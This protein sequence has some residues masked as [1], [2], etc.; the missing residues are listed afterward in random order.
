MGNPCSGIKLRVDVNVRGYNA[1]DENDISSVR[2]RHPFRRSLFFAAG[3]F[4][5]DSNRWDFQFWHPKLQEHNIIPA[6]TE[7]QIV[8]CILEHAV[9]VQKCEFVNHNLWWH[10]P[11]LGYVSCIKRWQPKRRFNF[12]RIYL[13]AQ[14][15]VHTQCWN[16][17]T[18]LEILMP[19][20][21]HIHTKYTHTH[22][23]THNGS[24]LRNNDS[25]RRMEKAFVTQQHNNFNTT[26]PE[27]AF[28]NS[29]FTNCPFICWVH[30][31]DGCRVHAML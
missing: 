14:T 10:V 15:S 28:N 4:E 5:L 2:P 23:H 19:R 26:I 30:C 31:C 18:M 22:T 29:K 7:W 3:D 12:G 9:Y 25:L 17:Y 16:A 1:G 20:H 6:S 8:H 13:R 21:V 11:Q 24:P 27:K